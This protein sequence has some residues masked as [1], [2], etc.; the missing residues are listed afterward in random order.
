M[1]HAIWLTTLVLLLAAAQAPAQTTPAPATGEVVESFRDP[2]QQRRF[3]ALLRD[4]RCMVCQNESLAES[5]A[6]LAGD[7]RRVVYE[8]ME[9]GRSDAEIR[10]FMVERFGEFVLYRPP[11]RPST[12]ALWFGPAIL[13]VFGFAAVMVMVRRRGKTAPVELSTEQRRRA[14]QL[15]HEQHGSKE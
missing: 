14:A 2:E 4:L 1:R 3:H 12:Y 15:L 7:L 10:A 9:A 11:M 13:L 8:Q 5:H 6:G